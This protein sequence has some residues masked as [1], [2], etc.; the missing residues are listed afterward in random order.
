MKE[1]V[2]TFNSI[3]EGSQYTMNAKHMILIDIQGKYYMQHIYLPS[4]CVKIDDTT[5]ANLMEI[6][7]HL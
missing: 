7:K 6:V 4:L 1:K 3:Y 5:Y 2:V